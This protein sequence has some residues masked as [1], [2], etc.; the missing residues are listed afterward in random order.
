MDT[1]HT[2]DYADL[3]QLCRSSMVNPVN[4]RDL[5]EFLIDS[6]Y[7]RISDTD[8]I[9]EMRLVDYN[10]DDIDIYDAVFN[11]LVMAIKNLALG[12]ASPTLNDG[13]QSHIYAKT[14]AEAYFITVDCEFYYKREPIIAKFLSERGYNLGPA[15]ETS[16]KEHCE[17]FT[18][19]A[20]TQDE[21]ITPDQAMLLDDNDIIYTSGFGKS[22]HMVVPIK[23][24]DLGRRWSDRCYRASSGAYMFSE[25]AVRKA[26][27]SAKL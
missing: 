3:V 24:S 1:K 19:L 15:P 6:K 9:G 14:E 22:Y 21:A 25:R 7:E 10:E 16:W 13:K 26:I 2:T 20:N 11:P 8:I 23:F 5:H 18:N 4:P 27:E 12:W 17:W